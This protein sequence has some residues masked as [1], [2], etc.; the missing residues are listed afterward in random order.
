MTNELDA[1][2]PTERHPYLELEYAQINDEQEMQ[3]YR[4]AA[5]RAGL[6]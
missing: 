4:R 2:Q 5:E 6:E 1:V 3:Q